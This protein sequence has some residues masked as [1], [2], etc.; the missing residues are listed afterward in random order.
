MPTLFHCLM[1]MCVCVELYGVSKWMRNGAIT[2]TNV[3][4]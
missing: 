4:C 3:D 1:A 2:V